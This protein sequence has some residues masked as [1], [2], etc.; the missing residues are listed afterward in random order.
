MC[1][2]DSLK[3]YI[4]LY[5]INSINYGVSSKRR[6]K[7]PV[8]KVDKVALSDAMGATRSAAVRLS[9]R[10]HR[11]ANDRTRSSCPH[12]PTT[13]RP[14]G[15]PSGAKPHGMLIAGCPVMLNG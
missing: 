2:R 6:Q 13:W 7:R 4:R 12:G 14:T 9:A 1:I 5:D 11:E 3:C 8:V 15:R 10:A